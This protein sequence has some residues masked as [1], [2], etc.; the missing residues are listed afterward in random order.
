MLQ[1]ISLYEEILFEK[2]NNKN[3]KIPYSIILLEIKIWDSEKDLD[4][5]VNKI[6]KLKKKVYI[7]KKNIN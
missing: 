7:G 1:F 6:D 4:Y 2:T 3:N 5:L